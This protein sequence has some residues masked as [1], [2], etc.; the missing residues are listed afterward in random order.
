MSVDVFHGS[1]TGEMSYRGG[2]ILF[3]RQLDEALGSFLWFEAEA[4][5]D[6]FFESFRRHRQTGDD[7]AN[8]ARLFGEVPNE[9]APRGLLRVTLAV[10]REDGD[11]RRE[12]RHIVR[13]NDR[14]AVHEVENFRRIDTS[15]Q[16]RESTFH[17]AIRAVVARAPL[18]C[19][20]E[21][22][23]SRRKGGA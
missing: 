22:F 17:N 6:D 5:G 19:F 12:K 13:R 2:S 16:Q 20:A 3:N 21:V 10:F 1:S 7:L 15:W 23:P 8:P 4:R 14:H 11:P 9:F 18:L